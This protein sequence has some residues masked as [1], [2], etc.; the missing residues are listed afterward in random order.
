MIFA[1]SSNILPEMEFSDDA[2]IFVT[3]SRIIHRLSAQGPCVIIRRLAD[4]LLKQNPHCFRVFA[5]SDIQSAISRITRKYNLPAPEAGEDI[6]RINKKR[7]NHYWRY[8]GQRWEDTGNH[9]LIWSRS[10]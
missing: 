1:D 2:A 8:T 3:E 7:A 4:F 6:N 9:D 5:Y 10:P